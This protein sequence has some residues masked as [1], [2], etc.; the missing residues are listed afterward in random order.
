VARTRW[1]SDLGTPAS[2]P[3]RADQTGSAGGCHKNLGPGRQI[4]SQDNPNG[5]SRIGGQ[6][7]TQAPDPTPPPDQSQGSRAGALS[8]LSL[9]N[10]A[11]AW[12]L[13]SLAPA[14]AERPVLA[15]VRHLVTIQHVCP[16]HRVDRATCTL[17]EC[18]FSSQNGVVGR[19]FGR[20]LDLV[21][22]GRVSCRE[23]VGQ[24]RRWGTAWDSRCEN[25]PA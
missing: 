4:V 9:P 14:A 18:R 20:Q 15:G 7:G 6:A 5:V 11:L 10:L 23:R 2:C 17:S 24:R 1:P 21:G 13:P 22:I 8:T 25:A 16:R 3:G 19:R 12:G